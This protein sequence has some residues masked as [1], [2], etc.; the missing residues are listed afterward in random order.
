MWSLSGAPE[1]FI[2]TGRVFATHTHSALSI[3]RVF[4][5]H[6][7]F[8]RCERDTISKLVRKACWTGAQCGAHTGRPRHFSASVSNIP[9]RQ[10]NGAPAAAHLACGEQNTAGRQLV[11]V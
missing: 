5:A 6:S 9:A 3:G 1:V 8:W 11:K 10:P 2:P 7:A 4:G